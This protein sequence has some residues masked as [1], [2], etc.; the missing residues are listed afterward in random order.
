V[1]VEKVFA[2]RLD[3]MN[4]PGYM[5]DTSNI[6]RTDGGSELGPGAEYRFDLTMPNNMGQVESFIRVKEVNPP[7][8]IVFDAGSDFVT[9]TETSTFTELPDG[10]THLEFAIHYDLPDEFKDGLAFIE[11]SGRTFFRTELAGL[12]SLMEGS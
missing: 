11:E 3:F 6:H 1:P 7:S 9:G 5:V 8:R 4:L 10:G 12:K 2:H